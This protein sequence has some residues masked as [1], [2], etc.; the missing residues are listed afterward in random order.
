MNSVVQLLCIIV[1][2]S[3]LS[4]GRNADDYRAE[5]PIEF[6]QQNDMDTENIPGQRFAQVVRNGGAGNDE[7][8]RRTAAEM[9]KQPQ[10]EHFRRQNQH[11]QEQHQ[12]SPITGQPAVHEQG[13]RRTQNPNIQAHRPQMN[14]RPLRSDVPQPTQARTPEEELEQLRRQHQNEKKED[15]KVPDKNIETDPAKEQEEPTKANAPITTNPANNKKI[16]LQPKETQEPEIIDSES[17]ENKTVESKEV[18]NKTTTKIENTNEPP[19]LLHHKKLN[20]PGSQGINDNT[21]NERTIGRLHEVQPMEMI[22]NFREKLQSARNNVEELQSRSR[23]Q[24]D[25]RIFIFDPKIPLIPRNTLK[26]LFPVQESRTGQRIE[27]SVNKQDSEKQIITSPTVDTSSQSS[28]EALPASATKHSNK[29]T[30][31]AIE[32]QEAVP[33][34]QKARQGEDNFKSNQEISQLLQ[35]RDEI[36]RIRHIMQLLKDHQLKQNFEQFQTSQNLT[37]KEQAELAQFVDQLKASGKISTSPIADPSQPGFQN[38]PSVPVD[39]NILIEDIKKLKNSIQHF[40]KKIGAQPEDSSDEASLQKLEE[41]LQKQRKE[42]ES[43]KLFIEEI[44]PPAVFPSSGSS[45]ANIKTPELEKMHLREELKSLQGVL[46]D[47]LDKEDKLLDNIHMGKSRSSTEGRTQADPEI[48]TLM[49]MMRSMTP[50]HQVSSGMDTESGTVL[51]KLEQI[52]REIKELD[53]QNQKARQQLMVEKLERQINQLKASPR[54]Q[55]KDE[56]ASEKATSHPLDKKVADL[57]KQ[58]QELSGPQDRQLETDHNNVQKELEKLHKEIERLGV[59]PKKERDEMSP[60]QLQGLFSDILTSDLDEE[61]DTPQNLP[62]APKSAVPSQGTS[63][64]SQPKTLQ[65]VY[66]IPFCL[67]KMLNY[68]APNFEKPSFPYPPPSP[69]Y[70]PNKQ[71]PMYQAPQ[72]TKIE[73][74]GYQAYP[75][76]TQEYQQQ[77][78]IYQPHR[79]V[80]RPIYIPPGYKGE[81]RQMGYQPKQE[82]ASKMT[83][84]Q[85][86]AQMEEEI[87]K[88]NGMLSILN[89]KIDYSQDPE[90][91]SNYEDVEDAYRKNNDKEKNEKKRRKRSADTEQDRSKLIEEMKQKLY[92]LKNQVQSVSEDD[93]NGRGKNLY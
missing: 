40:A 72:G 17:E 66:Q 52:E 62:T 70:Q 38:D 84:C 87:K 43:I 74:T 11:F 24:S 28:E 92:N 27:D 60:R 13:Y 45:T 68:P 15:R 55:K 93:V 16:I 1:F 35:V 33:D 54:I 75:P 30:N 69:A 19:Q 49:K 64:Y 79:P 12:R 39:T 23:I 18:D 63:Q 26:N 57:E 50:H 36:N 86:T 61:Q 81:I 80:V 34:M 22:R 47:L 41:Q 14:A 37:E 2:T 77:P 44:L 20:P 91:P 9:M 8:Y 78:P 71:F 48:G 65:P 56:K 73:P 6:M 51:A 3:K 32:E 59:K 67:Q 83:P 46:N 29:N 53:T 82:V 90:G 85:H 25:P 10:D 88:L 31:I 76:Q 89:E 58:L 42:I 4:F 21:R 5:I 7:Y